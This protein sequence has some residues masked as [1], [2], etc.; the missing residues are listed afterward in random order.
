MIFSGW[1]ELAGNPKYVAA[2]MLGNINRCVIW[3]SVS[4]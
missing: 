2:S 1:V 3:R 4:K